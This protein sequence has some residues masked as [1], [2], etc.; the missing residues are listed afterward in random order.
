[1]GIREEIAKLKAELKR[2]QDPGKMSTIQSEIGVSCSLNLQ[3]YRMLSLITT[4]LPKQ[5]MLQINVIREKAAEAEAIVKGIT[6]DI[7]RLDVAKSN[8]T[9]TIQTLERWAMLSE[10]YIEETTHAY[11]NILEQAHQQLSQ[12]LPTRRYKEISQ[13]LA[14]CPAQSSR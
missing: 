12:L 2:D 1:M 7:Q 13:A 14:V 4:Y 9:T 11:N 3:R 10:Y 6:S 5:L 8:L